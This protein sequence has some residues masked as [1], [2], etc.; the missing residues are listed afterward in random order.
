[1]AIK[2]LIIFFILLFSLTG[3]NSNSSQ[4]D[5]NTNAR[6]LPSIMNYAD[7]SVSSEDIFSTMPFTEETQPATVEERTSAATGKAETEPIITSEPAAETVPLPAQTT[8]AVVT[9]TPQTNQ[10]SEIKAFHAVKATVAVNN[11]A[12]LRGLS[13]ELEEAGTL[14][15][16]RVDSLNDAAL[17]CDIF[18]DDHTQT[19]ET[20]TCLSQGIAIY[21]NDFFSENIL[22]VVYL[23]TG[24]SSYK[25]EHFKVEGVTQGQ[26]LHIRVGVTYPSDQAK[27]ADESGYWIFVPVTRGEADEYIAYD[28]SVINTS[29]PPYWTEPIN[30]DWRK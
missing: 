4:T 6:T 14:P 30:P 13:K 23:K 16:F 18:K 22:Y 12:R 9:E 25:E 21:D 8:E 28:A 5:P 7:S 3:C 15:V 24:T 1:M 20:E 29:L 2:R 11:E 26:V 10:S 27:T 19:G 17:L